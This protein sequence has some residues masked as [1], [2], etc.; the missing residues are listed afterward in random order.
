M[1]CD[2]LTQG[3]VDAAKEIV[4]YSSSSKISRYGYEQGKEI[5][6]KSK[7]KFYLLI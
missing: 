3:V 1:R 2:V 4:I 6:D 7:P 5:L